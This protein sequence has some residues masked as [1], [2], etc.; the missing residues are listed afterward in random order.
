MTGRCEHVW[1]VGSPTRCVRCRK[2]VVP[3][4]KRWWLRARL[5]RL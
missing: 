1:S 5:W 2:P 4:W 3:W